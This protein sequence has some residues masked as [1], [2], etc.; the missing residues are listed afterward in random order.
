VKKRFFEFVVLFL[1][2]A[3][4]CLAQGTQEDLIK[5]KNAQYLTQSLCNRFIQMELLEYQ[6]CLSDLLNKKNMSSFT[7]LGIYHMGLVGAISAR[8]SSS[9]G[10]DQLAWTYLQQVK[11]LQRKMNIDD[12]RLCETI[13]GDCKAR[14]AIFQ[15]ISK[16]KPPPVNEDAFLHPPHLHQFNLISPSFSPVISNHLK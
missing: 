9:F 2:S 12:R 8:R 10:A 11:K 14:L 4:L 5:I 1:S 6:R 15:Q 16:K 7:R 3:T 13:E